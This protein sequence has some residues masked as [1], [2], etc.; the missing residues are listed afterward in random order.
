MCLLIPDWPVTVEYLLELIHWCWSLWPFIIPL[1]NTQVW[2]WHWYVNS[3]HIIYFLP[4]AFVVMTSSFV[5]I[6]YISCYVCG[7][8]FKKVTLLLFFLCT[9]G[10]VL[11]LILGFLA[12]VFLF[13]LTVLRKLDVD[14]CC[15]TL[16]KKNVWSD[17]C[18]CNKPIPRNVWH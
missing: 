13:Y 4:L 2:I 14:C 18:L 1:R 5:F 11:I 10:C 9:S 17:Y 3:D 8:Y 16:V 6:C 7:I 12:A 15:E